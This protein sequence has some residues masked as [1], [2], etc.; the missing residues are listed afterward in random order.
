VLAGASVRRE[1]V[2]LHDD[3]RWLAASLGRVIRR[4]EGE[5]AF[6]TIEALRRACRARRHGNPGAPS[7][8]A[9]IA[10]VEALSLESSAVTAR[11]FTLFF[12]LINTAEQVHRVRRARAYRTIGN[13]EPQPASARW[14]MRAMHAAGRGASEVERAMLGLDVRPV[15]TAHPTESTRRTLLALQSRVADLLLAREGAP[16]AESRAI[17][18]ALDGE[19]ELLWITA[20]VRQDRPSVKDEVS[21]VLWYLET[22]LLDASAR[23][24]D[25]LVRAFEEEFGTTS[26]AIQ[27][28]VPLRVGNWVGGDRD[29][30]P[31]VTPDVTIATARRASYAILGRYSDALAGLVERLSVSASIAPPSDELRAS[32]ESDCKLLPNVYEA[33]RRR[34]ADEPLRLKLSFMSARVESARRLTAARD[35][36]KAADEPAA[37]TAAAQLERD[38]LLVRESLVRAGATH[39]CRTTVDP[40]LA[41]VRAH[42]LY[43]YMMDV[44]DHAQVHRAALDDVAAQLGVAP[45]EGDS[46]RTEL[47]RRR[48]LVNSHVPLAEG[49]T[50]VLDTFR[51]MR[52]IQAEMGELSAS[53]YIVSMTTEPDDLLRVLLLARE[54]GLA[55]LAAESPVSR[56]DVVPLFE[57]LDDL[58]RAP[59]VMRALLD[60][61]LYRRQLAARG[62]RQE[63]MI[64]Y[65]DSGKDAGILASSW[66]LYQGQ[67]A[68][69]AVFRDAGVELRLFHGRGGSVG[70]GGGSPVSRALAALPPGTVNG[71]IKIT[72][73]GEIISQQFGLLPVAERT[74]EVTLAG[75]LLQ[76]FNQ[77][78]EAISADELREF[79]AVMTDLA[80]RGLSVYRELVHEHDALFRLFRTATPIDELAEARFGSRPAYRPGAGA[81]ITG[82]RA[83]PWGFGWTQIRLMLPG[84]LGA[85]TA[86]AHYASTSE[87]LGVLRRMA[88][89]WPFFDDLLGK[90][91]MVCAKTDL[92]IARAYVRNLGGDLALLSRLEREF[93]STV[94]SV[95]RIRDSATLLRDNP[96]L[97]SAIAL[98]NPYVDPLSLLQIVL[99]RRK[100][101]PGEDEQSRAAVDAVLATTLS[102]IAQ[103]LRNTG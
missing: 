13:A 78:P 65:S 87:G 4:L 50:R 95:L 83:I 68:L 28:L 22:R 47:T 41:V 98:R 51:A 79:R 96:V 89:R 67:E 69:A 70:R 3:V 38:L 85:G 92:E 17:E 53:T 66:A 7:L 25:A 39:A 77:W 16:L 21:T 32:I 54:T 11:A 84:W 40:L 30:N 61:P 91:E 81:G 48:P 45:L 42:G 90:I 10:Q 19:V 27:Q 5:A 71:R 36:G 12:L 15:L 43:G 102:G 14:A 75:A 33:N 44:R 9:L 18:E 26:E 73:Q 49:T 34:D 100:R 52:T 88:A 64:G 2:P 60:D 23:A 62:N 63:V 55:D 58:E 76:E 101:E 1:D 94:D 6:E 103:G 24:R 80:A 8:D 20:E 93:E 29:G 97:Q 31:G 86:L 74:L 46:L 72:E 57:T 99:L 82:I 37:Y 35:A 59:A 56:L